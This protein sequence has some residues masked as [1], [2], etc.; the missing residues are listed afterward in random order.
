MHE[1]AAQISATFDY[2]S[3]LF[4]PETMAAM[5]DNLQALLQAVIEDGDIA[6][7]QLPLAS[8]APLAL[9]QLP[10]PATKNRLSTAVGTPSARP[11]T[12]S[13]QQIIE[14]WQSRFG[15]LS[16]GPDDNFYAL[17]G[18]SLMLIG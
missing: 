5:A 14:L 2:N 8:L 16:I 1:E 4:T 7:A 10:Q 15:E 9:H 13:E 17:G 11:A 3:V 12:A 6:I 18:H